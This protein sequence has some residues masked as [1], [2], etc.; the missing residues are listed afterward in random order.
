MG[1]NAFL[2]LLLSASLNYLWSM[3]NTLQIILY[4]PLFKLSVPGNVGAFYNFLMM[5]AS[6]DIIPTQKIYDYFG[7][8]DVQNKLSQNFVDEG[9]TSALFIYNVGSILFLLALNPILNIVYILLKF[10]KGKRRSFL[11]RKK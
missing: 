5:I 10:C 1:G 3:I 9:Y 11:E 7:W 8:H 6:F 2:N 4:M